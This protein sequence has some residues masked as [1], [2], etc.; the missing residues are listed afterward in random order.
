MNVLRWRIDKWRRSSAY[1]GM[2]L[3]QQG[4][5]RN[6]LDEATLRGGAL[7]NDDRVLAKASGDQRAWPRLRAV[8]MAWFTL[9]TDGQYRNN[10]LD[11][12]LRKRALAND[13]QRRHRSNQRSVRN[14]ESDAAVTRDMTRHVTRDT[15]VTDSVTPL[16]PLQPPLQ[17]PVSVLKTNTE[18]GRARG[19]GNR[20]GLM[21]GALP[22]DHGDCL[23]HGPVCF[24]PFLVRKYLGR[25]GNDR[26]AMVA[27]AERV[28][29]RWTAKVEAGA[30]VPHGDDFAFWAAEY[31]ADFA[32]PVTAPSAVT[33]PIA[34]VEETR[35]L[36]EADRR[37][38]G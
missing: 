28:C 33:Y 21:A 22:I 30:R 2:D 14:R 34:G 26:A 12:E 7:P 31:D 9:G 27:W 29:A 19:A 32:A 18:T 25:F 5:Y 24:R 38:R 37:A 1:T 15:S 17:T 6:L 8:V 16:S 36:M 35:R 4:A 20:N 11:L 10:T 23:V 13:R 3:E